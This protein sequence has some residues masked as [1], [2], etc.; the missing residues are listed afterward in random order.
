VVAIGLLALVVLPVPALRSVGYAGMLVPLVSALA[1]LT[2]LP[3]LL[4]TIGRRADWPRS[5][6]RAVESR[7]WTSWARRVVSHP[8]L[9]CLTALAILAALATTALEL[10]VGEPDSS[11]LAQ[12]GAPTQVLQSLQR[13]GVGT[14]VLT[15]IEALAPATDATDVARTLA[16]VKGVEL[17]AAP[18]APG[19]RRDGRAAITI[20]PAQELSTTAGK[21]TLN[22]V[23]A[24]VARDYPGIRIGGAGVLTIDETNVF[25]GRFPLVLALIVL[26]WQQ[27]HGSHAIWGTPATGAITNWV[28]LMA[29]AFL[30]GL[31]MDH[32]VFILTPVREEYDQH[33][34]TDEA[35]I[36][37]IGRTGRLVASAALILF[38]AF[39]ALTAAPETGLRI[40][41]TAL[42]AGILLD[43]TVVRALLVPALLTLLGRWNWWPPAWAARR[44]QAQP[45]PA[46][47][48]HSPHAT[49]P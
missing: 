3:V 29:F 31:S 10:R 9:A 49:S 19:W 5:S 20:V 22:R 44:P 28:P 42:G 38:L 45:S 8:W 43:A 40:M 35:I 18:T 17:A 11:S 27:G 37:A 24:T 1:A 16:A 13:S 21:A 39:A 34:S 48:E 6:R 26:V 14:G 15:P 41:A 23:R 25:Y 7:H 46:D 32:E 4:A 33:G 12:P 30:Y 2:V 36:H 47:A